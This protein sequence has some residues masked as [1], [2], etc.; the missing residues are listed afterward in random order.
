MTAFSK[1]IRP[2]VDLPTYKWRF[3]KM[4]IVLLYKYNDDRI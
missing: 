4:F 2:E 1:A 3:R